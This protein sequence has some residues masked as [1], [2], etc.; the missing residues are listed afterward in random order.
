MAGI[1]L[2]FEVARKALFASQTAIQVTSHNI[3]NVNTP[4]YSRQEA[5]LTEAQAMST[6]PGQLGMGTIVTGIRRQTDSLT[7]RQLISENGTYASLNYTSSATGQ[8]E[9]IF[10]DVTGAGLASRVS[11]FFN[12]WDDLSS[13]PQ[14]TAE[15]QTVVSTADLLTA[16][17]RN[18]DSQLTT[19][20]SNANKDI[21]SITEEV[22]QIAKQ[23]ASINGEIKNALVLGQQPNDLMDQ[24]GALL[25]SL[26]EKIGYSSL[27]D[28]FGQVNVYVGNGRTLIDG[29]TAGSL[30]ADVNTA[31]PGSELLYDV[32]IRLPGQGG[33][34]SILDTI[35]GTITSGEL[36]A[37]IRFRDDYLTT[38]RDRVDQL[39][40]SINTQ[41]NAQHSQGYGLAG[42]VPSNGVNFFTAIVPADPLKPEKD[43]ARNFHVASNI[44]SDLRLIAAARVEGAETPPALPG[45]NRNSLLMAGLRN[46]SIPGLGN[47]TVTDY[48]AG[49][50]GQVGSETKGVNLD[51]QHQKVVVNYLETRREEVSGVS[52][53]EEMT[54]LIRFQRGFEAATKLISVLDTLLSDIMNLK[55]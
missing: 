43:A 22:N 3:A 30:I 10:N 14:G 15:R 36:G 49:M 6:S 46:L 47:A 32:K 24:R 7:E 33:P 41:V 45:D 8:V 1:N 13:N 4:G 55:K 25:K 31:D 26:A 11:E 5:I 29:E 21:S 28:S 12:S 37:A 19:L 48:I 35:T 53:D 23:I 39:A 20:K 40:Y 2:A 16:E 17:F 18:V 52:L 44:A 54:N 42:S 38:V 9:G 50:V 27:T 34:V 51:L